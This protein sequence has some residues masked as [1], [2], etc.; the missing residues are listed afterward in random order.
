MANENELTIAQLALKMDAMWAE[1]QR[2]FDLK[3]ES[4]HER[5]DHLDSS[6]SSSKKTRG[7]TPLHESSDSNLEREFYENE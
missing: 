7:K 4:I 1:V 5:I 6:K 3:F 2:R